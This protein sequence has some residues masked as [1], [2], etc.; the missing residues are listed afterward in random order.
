MICLLCWGLRPVVAATEGL[1]AVF[2]AFDIAVVTG[3]HDQ[4]DFLTSH[5][6]QVGRTPIDNVPPSF[7]QLGGGEMPL[8]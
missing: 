7:L 5:R 1:D 6:L 8:R 3:G 2:Q 4:S